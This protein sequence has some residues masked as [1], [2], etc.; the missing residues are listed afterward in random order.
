[1]I[2]D[3]TGAYQEMCS[4]LRAVVASTAMTTI[5]GYTPEI[6]YVDVPYKTEPD[7][8]KIWLRFSIIQGGEYKRTLQRPSRVTYQG[9]ADI[10]LF[11]PSTVR[12]PAELG[13][14]VADKLML[15]YANST[16]SVDF[17]KAAIRDMPKEDAWFYKRVNATYYY[18][19]YV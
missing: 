4:A 17:T 5:V 6:R 3:E 2:T 15:V 19:N 13:R 1:M 14:R 7:K 18:E 8:T 11:V 9:I 16:A 12:N 10:Q